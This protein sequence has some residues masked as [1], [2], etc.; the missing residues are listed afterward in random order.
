M[1]ENQPYTGKNAGPKVKKLRPDLDYSGLATGRVMPQ[2]VSLEEAILGALMIDRDAF[3]VV[4]GIINPKSFYMPAHTTIFESMM[5]M[6]ERHI[7]IDLLTVKEDLKKRQELDAIGGAAYLARLTKKVGSAA[8]LEYHARIVAQKHVQ[9]ELIRVSTE[10]IK[11]SFED[12]KDVF[13]ILDSA[14]Q[15]LFDITQNNMNRGFQK[16]GAIVLKAREVLEELK[17]KEDGLTGVATGYT[18]L[19]RYT[20]GWQNSDLII[21]A[22]RPGMGK[23]TLALNMARNAAIDFNVPVGVFSL[24]MSALQLTQRLISAESR[25]PGSKLRNG[26]VSDQDMSRLVRGMESIQEAPIYIDDTPGINIF[27]LRAKCRRM[28][29]QHNVGMI[30]IDYLQLMT[31]GN[32]KKMGNRQ[33]EI[34]SISR[35]LKGMAK[36]LNIPVIALSQLSRDVEKRGGNKRPVLSDLRESGAIEQDADIVTFIYRQ[37]YYELQEGSEFVDENVAE[38]ILA[39]H[40]NGAT[41]TIQIEYIKEYGLFKNLETDFSS[42][43]GPEGDGGYGTITLGSRINDGDTPNNSDEGPFF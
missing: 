24:E 30:V 41:G 1:A 26:N 8:N 20:S 42:V 36:E 37:D 12:T 3:P 11:D 25:I 31:S 21:L 34:S 43:A 32:E 2:A 28:K 5:D 18:E 10:T 14:E 13:D 15:G 19:D 33:E 39:K 38:V 22:A 7:P 27:E 9:R 4:M 23:T 17:D 16:I 6:Y 40:R 35:S 29:T